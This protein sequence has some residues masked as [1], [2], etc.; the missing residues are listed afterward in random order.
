MKEFYGQVSLA[1]RVNFTVKAENEE[2]A[3][4]KVFE[5]IEGIELYLKD[6][7]KVEVDFIDW[8]LIYEAEKGNVRE[9]HIEDFYIEEEV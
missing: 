6:G 7:S 3:T 9:A 1:G 8:E 2:I 4:E 5:D